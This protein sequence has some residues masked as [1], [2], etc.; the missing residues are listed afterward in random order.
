MAYTMICSQSAETYLAPLHAHVLCSDFISRRRETIKSIH[1]I[2][3]LHSQLTTQSADCIIWYNVEVSSSYMILYF[4]GDR[5]K[6]AKTA[7]TASARGLPPSL[8]S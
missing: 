2:S 3:I 4:F 5:R 7:K 6:T 1:E 8:K